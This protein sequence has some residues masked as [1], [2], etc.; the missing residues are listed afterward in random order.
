MRKFVTSRSKER[1]ED[2]ATLFA[3]RIEWKGLDGKVKTGREEC[4]A[5]LKEQQ[6]IGIKT[7][8]VNDWSVLPEWS[9]ANI[10]GD[11]Y[12]DDENHTT[13]IARRMVQ[14]KM[15]DGHCIKA[16]QTAT[17][18]RGLIVR[19]NVARQAQP[20]E[21]GLQPR[22]VLSR[23]A[24]LRKDGDDIGAAEYL[25]DNIQWM[26]L[27]MPNEPPSSEE[28]SGRANVETLWATHRDLKIRR[29]IMSDWSPGKNETYTRSLKISGGPYGDGHLVTQNARVTNGK[30][31]YIDHT[32]ARE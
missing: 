6:N 4:I 21:P 5:S 22:E 1:Y 9:R 10:E 7:T 12:E 16:N 17:V 14:V 15:P 20:W 2:I 26:K 25:A 13:Y 30:I 23:F 28:I 18:R 27:G 24:V 29:T 3:D 11:N 19:V 31:S 8:Q 32:F